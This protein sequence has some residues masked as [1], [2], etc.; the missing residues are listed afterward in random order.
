MHIQIFFIPYNILANAE[1]PVTTSYIVLIPVLAALIGWGTNHLAVKMLFHPQNPINLMGITIQGVFPKRQTQL[2]EKLGTLV[3]EE[4]FSVEEIS[5]RIKNFATRDE[6]MNAVENRIEKTIREKLVGAFPMLTM[7]LT[8][9]MIQKVT[10]LFKTELEDF[11]VQLASELSTQLENNLDVRE[12]VRN[13]VLAF[14]SDKLEQLLFEL[15]KKEFR[16]IEW[17]GAVLGFTIGCLQVLL[18]MAFEIL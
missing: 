12:V 8:D 6:T 17:V 11:I 3:S 14:S 5:G 2:A 18:A 13:K 10:R 9:D 4:L 1:F 7:F 16:F 15:M